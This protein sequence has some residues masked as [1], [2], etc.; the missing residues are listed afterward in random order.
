MIV[1]DTHILVWW[2]S[3][4][5]GCMSGEARAAIDAELDGGRLCVSSISAWEIAMLVEQGRLALA[6]DVEEWLTVVA[7]IEAVEFVPADNAMAVRSVNLP[8]AFHEDP[9]D[10]LIVATARQLGAPIVSADSAIHAY[11]HVRS[12]G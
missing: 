6:M 3:G 4:D 7:R 11:P 2:A 8:G 5:V 9:A 12:I 1:V 10:R